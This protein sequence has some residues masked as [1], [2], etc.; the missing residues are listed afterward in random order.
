M[1]KDKISISRKSFDNNINHIKGHFKDYSCNDID[2]LKFDL[3]SS[4]IHIRPSN[5]EPIVRIIAES[6]SMERS[7]E[8][9]Q[10]TKDFM[11]ALC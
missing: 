8:L 4:W 3:D 6:K 1:V 7:N 2:G 9:V 11:R 10:E 5:T